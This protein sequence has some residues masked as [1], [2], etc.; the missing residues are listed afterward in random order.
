MRLR[1]SP[2]SPFVRKVLICAHEKGI[3]DR[4]ELVATAPGTDA[5]LQAENPLRQ[6]PSLVTD[7]G[8]VLFDSPVICEYLEQLAPQPALYPAGARSRI[9]ALRLQAIGDGIGDA[10]LARRM[11]S[12]RPDGEKSPANMARLQA[13][14]AAAL[15]WLEANRDGLDGTPT[16]GSI[17]VACGLGYLGL[18]FAHEDWR[19]GRPGLT[20]WYESFAARPSLQATTPSG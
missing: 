11:E 2:A 10:A 16:I 4:F 9:V 14:V 1:Y 13:R 18:R 12:M 15:D 8:L 3:A 6:I 19:P 7:D 5:T 17:A 20:A